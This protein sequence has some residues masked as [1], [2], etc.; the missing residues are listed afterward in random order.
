MTQA[1]RD[2]REARLTAWKQHLVHSYNN[3][4]EQTSH[5]VTVTTR[6]AMR[7]ALLAI[8]RGSARGKLLPETLD[9]SS[10]LRLSIPN[11]L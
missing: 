3:G 7:S 1:R 10:Q 8:G 9:E 2:R 11:T 5:I 6:P 4:P